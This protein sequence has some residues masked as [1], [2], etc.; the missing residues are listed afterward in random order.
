MTESSSTRPATTPAPG[1]YRLDP[2]RS[3]VRVDAKGMFGLVP[4]HGTM[5]LTS[6][7]VTIADDPERS[8]VQAVIDAGSYSS[9]NAKRDTDVTSANLLDA[10]S[11]PEITFSGE[12]A[13]AQ[14]NSWVVR[15]TVTAH[16]ASVPTE[17]TIDDVRTEDGTGRFHATATLDRT[18][19]GVTKMKAMVGRTAKVIIDAVAVPS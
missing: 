4:V 14:G 1:T 19:F 6:G 5:R 16:G 10:Q 7:E 9:G 17:L 8:S 12:G 3:T 18:Q 2:D 13:R 15:G 11:Y